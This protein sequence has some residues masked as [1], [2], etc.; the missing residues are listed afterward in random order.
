M[1]Y[2]KKAF[3]LL[4]EDIL[5]KAR[6]EESLDKYAMNG[7]FGVLYRLLGRLGVWEWLND[8]GRFGKCGQVVK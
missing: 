5:R 6:K 8:T 7:D 4:C 3:M 1:I 2:S